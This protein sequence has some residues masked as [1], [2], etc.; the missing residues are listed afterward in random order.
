MMNNILQSNTAPDE[1]NSEQLNIS[2]STFSIA[3][4]NVCGLSSPTKQQQILNL[5][6]YKNYDI[7]G[8]SETK[9]K[10]VTSKH[11]FKHQDCYKSWWNCN[12]DS[13]AS[14]GVGLI[15]KKDIVTFVQFVHGYKGREIYANLYLKG[16]FKLRIM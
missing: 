12:D 4:N 3:T 7:F 1:L 14:S 15:I 8:L 9:L 10:S 13:P 16:H 11:L 2:G 6:E 5:I